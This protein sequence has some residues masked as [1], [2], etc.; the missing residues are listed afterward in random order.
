[1]D[2]QV[3]KERKSLI[4]NDVNAAVVVCSQA[5]KDSMFEDHAQ[6][7]YVVVDKSAFSKSDDINKG[8]NIQRKSSDLAYI[9]YTSGTTGKPKGCMIT[10]SNAV[11]ALD[12][13]SRSV[14]HSASS[15][16][17]QF[18]SFAFDVSVSE[19]FLCWL[20]GATLVSAPADEVLGNLEGTISSCNITHTGLTPTV[21]AM[22]KPE[23]TLS[24]QMI[25]SGGE[26]MTQHLL[27]VWAPTGKLY[28]AYG[29]TETTIGVAMCHMTSP[30]FRPS[31]L[32]MPYPTVSAY[33]VSESLE[34][35]PRGACGELCLGGPQVSN[36]YLNRES[37]NTASF[38]SLPGTSELVYRT[39]D[40]ARLLFDGT[41]EYLGRKDRQ[42]K[43]NGL[44]IELDEIS[45]VIKKS[46]VLH[47][48]TLVC[49][50]PLH[51]REQLVSFV[52]FGARVHNMNDSNFAEVICS[53]MEDCRNSLAPYMVPSWAIPIESLPLGISNKLDEKKLRSMF[54][55]FDS[56][57]LQRLASYQEAVTYSDMLRDSRWNNFEAII[58]NALHITSGIP[59]EQINGS[60]SIFHLG[61][62]SISAVQL[63]SLLKKEGI[64]LP[65]SKILANRTVEQMVS[66]AMKERSKII[67]E[68]EKISLLAAKNERLQ[69]QVALELGGKFMD[70]IPAR[71]T[72]SPD[73]I[74]GVYP[75]TPGQIFTISAWMNSHGNQ[76]VSTFALKSETCLDSIR[77]ESAIQKLLHRNDIFRTAFVSTT[78]EKM[79]IV[80]VVLK[81]GVKNSQLYSIETSS[82]IH[83]STEG[84]S[85]MLEAISQSR[86]RNFTLAE[87]PIFIHSLNFADTTIL[88]F[89]MHHA[90]YDGWSLRLIH[91][92]LSTLYLMGDDAQVDTVSYIDFLSHIYTP[93]ESDKRTLK[94]SNFVKSTLADAKPCL[95][96]PKNG[97]ATILE[98]QHGETRINATIEYSASD[99]SS[100]WSKLIKI[101]REFDLSLQS[102]F[103]A[104]WSQTLS[105]YIQN[106]DALFGV[107][108]AGRQDGFES[109]NA[110]CVNI[111]PLHVSRAAELTLLEIAKAI[112]D[113]LLIQQ[114]LGL[115]QMELSNVLKMADLPT[116]RPMFNT[117]FN[118]IKLPS[119]AHSTVDGNAQ[120]A[121]NPF[122]AI[123]VRNVACYLHYICVNRRRVTLKKK[124]KKK[125]TGILIICNVCRHG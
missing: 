54:E 23:N 102:I 103:M 117:Y 94:Q 15:R 119:T 35:V 5:I 84:Q 22:I 9:L 33:V 95:L 34:I 110:P 48:A 36:G 51:S 61:L 46:G 65:V 63:S 112:Q 77:L 121:L 114:E 92:E 53:I 58:K 78:S 43:L 90:L 62:D 67:T 76:F 125:T 8:T 107:Y 72:V 60:S 105:A 118:F 79:P 44:R 56:K 113:Q 2:V 87:P 123:Q 20:V 71:L 25:A 42:V 50:H 49:R 4:F 109:L 106:S 7:N 57:D 47:V 64:D 80:Q 116:T 3:P 89:N 18:A 85:V 74:E 124:K 100:A 75:C 27:D 99:K 120:P 52:S 14:P 70:D 16:F 93:D 11:T 19:M 66:Y 31:I 29:P 1:V 111:S 81:K 6:R 91:E 108:N 59:F 21:A 38:V 10:H 115:G 12:S 40:L 17:L 73:V 32:G 104:A 83:D 41:I 39:G 86:N 97:K 101:S 82:A 37:L 24:L 69:Q 13:F 96:S 88:L 26:K 28:N 68:E 45:S 122:K 55:E 98:S 30:D